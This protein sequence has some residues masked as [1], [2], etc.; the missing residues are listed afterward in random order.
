MYYSLT[1]RQLVAG[2]VC[3]LLNRHSA[4]SGKSVHNICFTDLKKGVFK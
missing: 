3:P 2:L 1:Y 4:E